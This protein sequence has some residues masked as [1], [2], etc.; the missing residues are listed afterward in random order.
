MELYMI[1]T[2]NEVI[3]NCTTN[4]KDSKGVIAI[5]AG[6][7]F[8]NATG[9]NHIIASTCI[10]YIRPRSAIYRIVTDSAKQCIVADSPDKNI[11]VCPTAQAVISIFT[12]QRII[13]GIAR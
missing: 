3:N 11:V 2:R 4:T 6:E 9:N 10:Y 12:N 5:T 7:D 1:L 13:P 8:A